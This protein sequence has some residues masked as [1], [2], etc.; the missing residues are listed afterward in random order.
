MFSNSL[1]DSSAG[2]ETTTAS[3][4]NFLLAMIHYPEI[5]RKAQAELDAV[6]GRDRV[7]TFSDRPHL[8]YMRAM[9]KELLRWRPAGPMGES[10]SSRLLPTEFT[11]YF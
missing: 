8:P 10:F 2:A 5:M 1:Y 4:S 6:V 7:P 3:V 11:I 9:V